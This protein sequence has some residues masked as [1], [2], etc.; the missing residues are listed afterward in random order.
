MA[1]P[2]K[3]R[4]RA[5]KPLPEPIDATPEELAEA[6]LRVPPDHEWDYLK[7][8]KKEGAATWPLPRFV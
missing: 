4:G 5:A 6:F 8:N 3:P 7:D 1:T 2:K